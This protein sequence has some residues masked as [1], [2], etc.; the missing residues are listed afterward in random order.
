MLRNWLKRRLPARLTVYLW[1][2]LR[3]AEILREI[4]GDG[5]REEA[6]LVLSGVAGVVTALRGLGEWRTPVLLFDVCVR[7]HG[8]NRFH[9]RRLSDDLWH[10]LPSLEIAVRDA[11]RDHLGSGNVFVDAGANIGVLTVVGARLVG[12]DGR[13]LAIEM[14]PETARALRRNLAAN[15]LDAVQVVEAA[16]S[17]KAGDQVV[18]RIPAGFSGQ[19]SIVAARAR[20][21]GLEEVRVTT[22]T[23]DEVTF[24][25]PDLDVLK[26][27]LEG[28]EN[29][30]LDGGR[31]TLERTRCVIF[32]DWGH[33]QG[34]SERLSALG[35]RVERLDRFNFLAVR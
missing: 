7:V 28:A 9:C 4:R 24:D 33:G 18:A 6:K 23:L 13:I 22:T 19:A 15:G 35:F 21:R 17:D 2:L 10:L 1:R 16:L 8:S 32:E 25:L 3:W 20:N 30:A 31:A 11:L 12:R 29:L 27:D 14:V 5:W 34:I 26:L